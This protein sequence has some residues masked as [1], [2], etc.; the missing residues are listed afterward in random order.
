M[1]ELTLKEK[2]SQAEAKIMTEYEVNV[3]YFE[4]MQNILHGL[5]LRETKVTRKHRISYRLDEVHFDLDTF[6]GIPTFL[7]IEAPTLERVQEYVAKLGFSMAETKPWSG[8]D[9]LRY[10]EKTRK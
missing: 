9:L 1:V 10:Y 3:N 7:E 5:G 2:I 4:T 6:P 8:A